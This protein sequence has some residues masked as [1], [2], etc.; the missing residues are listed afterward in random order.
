MQHSDEDSF[1]CPHCG[2]ELAEDARF[3]RHC[4]ASEDSGWN[5]SDYSEGLAGDYNGSEEDF[6]YDDFLRREFPEA[7]QS[8]QGTSLRTAVWW[9]VVLLI[10][11]SFLI[12]TVGF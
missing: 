4:G 12:W 2:A 5:E 9:T 6:D 1:L 11:S 10:I 3:C 8:A 7:A